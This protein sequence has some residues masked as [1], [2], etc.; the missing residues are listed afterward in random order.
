MINHDRLFKELLMEFFADFVELF[1]ADLAVYLDKDSLEFLD[2]EVFTDVTSGES[3]EADLVV[4]A[5]FRNQESYFLMHGEHQAQPQ[6]G[7][8][9]RMFQYFA[10]LHEKHARPVYPIVIFSHDSARL[11]P[12]L[13]EVTF[14]DLPVL[15]FQYR[16]IQLSRL[17]WRD[18]MN[19]PNPVASALMAKMKMTPEERPRVKLECLRLLATLKLN[20]ARMRLIS[21]FVDTYL[22]LTKEETL[23]FSRQADTL[24][25][26]KEKETIMQLTTS[27]KEEGR[28]EG[29]QE[30]RY[31]A[32]QQLVLRL[33]RRRWRDL[34]PTV[35][36]R[37]RAL[38]VEQL[39]LLGEDL[40][41]FI[42]PADLE[43]W[44]NGHLA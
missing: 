18:F 5:R 6:A 26:R 39:E 35:E 37:V 31:E 4:K 28:Q 33:L 41:D 34:N 19:R 8:N 13:Y 38:P 44:L 3:H 11:E 42:A 9:R 25:E 32:D 21:G 20:P 2:K 30:G 40:L 16:T 1:L 24:L 22:R 17:N 14:P 29:R 7:F 27:W 10:R 43:D 36:A 15:R 23:I 12:D